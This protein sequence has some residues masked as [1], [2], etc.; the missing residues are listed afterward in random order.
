MQV[1]KE[2]FS[3]KV[4]V[5]TPTGEAIELPIGSTPV[6]F[7]Y[8]VGTSIGNTMAEVYVNDEIVDPLYKLKNKDRVR[9]ITSTLSHGP[10]KEWLEEVATTKAKEMI[11]QYNKI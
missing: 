8:K 9:I 7:A 6:D 1:K 5:Y 11:K 2:L 4:Y 3:D 10:R